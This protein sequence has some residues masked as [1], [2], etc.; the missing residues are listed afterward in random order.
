MEMVPMMTQVQDVSV[1][2][3]A[4]PSGINALPGPARLSASP[5][6]FAVLLQ[7][8]LPQAPADAEPSI[9]SSLASPFWPTIK[10][11]PAPF[12]SSF[13][14]IAGSLRIKVGSLLYFN[15]RPA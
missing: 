3:S 7:E 15:P 12:R 5:L 6:H 10:A 11:L 4:M 14:V 9:S 2:V 8:M 13:S 1:P